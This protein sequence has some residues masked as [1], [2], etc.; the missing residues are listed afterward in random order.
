MLF[1]DWTQEGYIYSS[2]IELHLWL[3]DLFDNHIMLTEVMGKT[4]IS[5]GPIFWILILASETDTV[6]PGSPQNTFFKN[7]FEVYCP[8]WPPKVFCILGLL[9][10]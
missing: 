2:C 6:C 10:F 5:V 1:T 9:Q 4:M 7:F 3:E 8:K